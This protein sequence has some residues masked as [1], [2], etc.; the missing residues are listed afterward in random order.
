MNKLFKIP[1]STAYLLV[2][3]LNTFVDLGH[4]I[5]LQNTIF[6]VYDG[7]TQIVLTAIINGLILLPFILLFSPAGFISDRYPKDAVMRFAAWAAIAITLGITACYYLGWFWPAFALTFLLAVQSAIYSPAKYAYIRKLFGKQNLTE[8][9]G[10]VQAVTIAAILLGTFAFSIVFESMFPA[11]SDKGDGL[12][13]IAPIGWILVINSALELIMAYRLPALDQGNPQ[14]PFKAR[15]YF[16]GRS[17]KSHIQPVISNR[18]IRL[19]VIGLAVF[20][21]VG[22]VL[23]AAFPAFAKETL[24]ISNTVVIQGILASTGIG[25]ALGSTL[26]GKWSKGHIETGL[27]PIGAAGIGIGLILLPQLQSTTAHIV[28]FLF[29]GVMGGLFIVPLNALIQFV[30]HDHEL[31]K[32]IAGNN[33]IQNISMLSFLILTALF[34]VMGIPSQWLLSIIAVA[35]IIGGFYTVYQLPQSLVRMVLTG[36]IRHRCKVTVQGFNNI[37]IDGSALLLAKKT[38]WMDWAIVQIASPRPIRFMMPMDI[39]EH[40]YLKGFFKRLNCIPF[41]TEATS[42]ELCNTVI[43]LLDGGELVCVFYEETTGHTGAVNG[44][45]EQACQQTKTHTAIIPFHLSSD[46]LY[47]NSVISFE[48]H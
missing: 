48:Q 7:E 46:D 16:S 4:K 43:E 25:I 40:R 13:A 17:M 47:R 5:T 20:W 27:V 21:S 42:Q 12:I 33:L 8:A 2:I 36:I 3:F 41:N 29:I 14:E 19:A 39:Y 9:N 35:A 28:N 38:S 15:E 24:Q 18:V 10:I 32:V 1:G 34:A 11:G 23:L 26:A 6:K 37:P 45:I 31:G 22:Q 44:D 30:A